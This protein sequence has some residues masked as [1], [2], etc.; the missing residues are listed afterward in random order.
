MGL[1]LILALEVIYAATELC[2]Y[3]IHG[4]AE[5]ETPLGKYLVMIVYLETPTG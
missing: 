2:A 1:G 3:V 5:L 4:S